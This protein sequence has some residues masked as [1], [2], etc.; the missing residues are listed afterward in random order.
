MTAGESLKKLVDYCEKE[1]YKGYD[2]YDGLN[3]RLFQAL[4]VIPKKRFPRLVWIKN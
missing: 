1:E 4:P 2:P 3:S